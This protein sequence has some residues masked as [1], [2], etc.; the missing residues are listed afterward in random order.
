MS[1]EEFIRDSGK[2]KGIKM[3]GMEVT[4]VDAE[5]FLHFKG[6]TPETQGILLGII[7]DDGIDD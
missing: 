6:D 7:Y 5:L 2:R 4:L 1:T 3:M